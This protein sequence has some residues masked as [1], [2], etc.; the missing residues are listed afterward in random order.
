M[1]N[2]LRMGNRANKQDVRRSIYELEESIAVIETA[3][4]GKDT[5]KNLRKMADQYKTTFEKT[6][7]EDFE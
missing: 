4:G 1:E 6:Y 2:L 7:G 3:E 5:A